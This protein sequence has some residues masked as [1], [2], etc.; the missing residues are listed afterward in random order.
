MFLSITLGV[1]VLEQEK[2][3]S[4]VDGFSGVKEA[5]AL[6]RVYTISPRQGECFYLRLLL[7]HVRGPKSFSDLRIINGNLCSSFRENKL[8]LLEDDNRYHLAMQ[9]LAIRLQA[10]GHCLQ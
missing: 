1:K 8:D 9:E 3:G 6:G 5:R 10:F 7:H 2:E 4:D